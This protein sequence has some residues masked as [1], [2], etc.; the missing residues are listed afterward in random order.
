MKNNRFYSQVLIKLEFS[1]HIIE[2]VK[3][4]SLAKIRPFGAKFFHGDSRTDK[5]T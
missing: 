2:N 1:R 5:Q 4:T 3:I